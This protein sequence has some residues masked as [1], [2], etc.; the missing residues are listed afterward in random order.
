MNIGSYDLDSLRKLVRR[1]EK[2]N[3]QLRSVLKKEKIPFSFSEEDVFDTENENDEYDIDQGGRIADR[4]IDNDLA[5][6]FYS[7]F[8]GR[9]DVFA[10]RSKNG[11]YFPQC[12]NRWKDECPVKQGKERTCPK[13]C[14][15]RR[16]RRLEPWIIAKHLKGEKEDGTDVIGAY[17]LLPDGTCRFIVF[18]FDNH[19]KG[20]G[21]DDFKNPD[22]HFKDEV[23]ALRSICDQNEV[24]YVVERSRSGKGAHLWIFFDKPISAKLARNFGF[25]LLD[26]G[27]TSVNLRSFQYY[28]RIYPS[29]NVSS[30]IGNLIALPLQG[31][32]LKKGNSAFI[33]ENWNAYAD[34]WNVLFNTRKLKRDD[35]LSLMA[36]WQ[37]DLAQEKGLLTDFSVSERP[38][39]WRRNDKFSDEDVIG[40]LHIVLGDGV[41]VDALNLM[42]RLQNQI[43]SL[44][45]FD[46]PIFY[47][48]KA[49][50]YSNYYN[51]STIYLGKDI[52]GY[53]KLPRGL[54]EKLISELDR[55]EIPY[56]IEDQRNT[57]RPIRVEFKGD[58]RTKQ[59]LA[60]EAMFSNDN[61]ILNAATGF[62]KT[63]IASYLIA[64]RK[65]NTLIIL[66]NSQLIDQWMKELNEF[67]EIG[68]HPAEYETK[69][70]KKKRRESVIGILQANKDT[71]SGI[72]DIA[73]VG[74]LY[75]KGDFHERINS[76]G[77]VIIDECQHSA[78]N[79]FIEVLKKIDAKYVYGLSANLDRSD[80]LDK[81]TLMM[82]G[83]IRHRY[84][85]FQR[86]LD[87]KIR[88]YIVPRF[89]RVV[90]FE[91]ENDDINR[92]YNLICYHKDRNK[93]IVQDV[94]QCISTGKT[95]L[96][97]TRFKEHAKLLYEE[98]KEDSDHVFLVYGDNSAKENRAILG[99]LKSIDKSE[100][101]ILIATGQMIG[102]G[103]DFPRLDVLFLTSPVSREGRLE[104]FVGRVDRI[105]EGKEEVFVYDYIDP[106]ISSFSKMYK[107]RLKI[108]KKIGF[109]VSQ[110]EQK[111]RQ[112]TD[113][114]YDYSSYSEVFERDLMNANKSIVISSGSIIQ[115]KI[116]RLIDIMSYKQEDGIKV[117]VI[118]SDADNNA[119]ENSDDAIVLKMIMDMK[120]AGFYVYCKDSV[121]ECFAIIDDD[122]VWYGGVNLLGKEDVRDNLIRLKDAKVA[123]EL[124]EKI[125]ERSDDM[126]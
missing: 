113:A 120:N 84:T 119:L 36:K 48:N 21:A 88:H 7:M 26:K 59:D 104:Q 116:D 18:D 52:D 71:L 96:I 74:S 40:N 109:G 38:R 44:C 22:D 117:T 58:L 19:E 41:Y 64:M 107:K 67:L 3:Q 86:S 29:Q 102:E 34:Q 43:R 6:M 13:D 118:T 115:D 79:T 69:G 12:E 57:G 110:R 53:I 111:D 77:M 97:L 72:I 68:E 8:W 123:A 30:G 61:G 66:Q 80:D 55:G 2:E 4:Y 60:A 27:M 20:S 99:G 114:I 91:Q 28:D 76:Y 81:I 50:G 83:P 90:D 39:P 126:T 62:G 35:V 46:N 124:E 63:V 42:P 5:R 17:P 82:I 47:K 31:D 15:L 95:P 73:M 51:F 10:R 125:I 33:D 70:G 94:R 24:P 1:L 93:Q 25:L 105:F 45:A 112:S 106:H 49:L 121:E 89:T 78:S 32:A 92:L 9:T 14:A 56:D 103:F 75:K 100:T 37:A 122:L 11:N 16:Y 87:N 23:N 54:K 65:L 108:Y 98:L 85:A 101:I